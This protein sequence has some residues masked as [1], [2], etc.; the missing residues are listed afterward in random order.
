[1]WVI[2]GGFHILPVRSDCIIEVMEV[3][4]PGLKATAIIKDASNN[5]D[6]I[7]GHADSP[8]LLVP[9]GF[10]IPQVAC[11]C[12]GYTTLMMAVVSL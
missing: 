6:G 3:F 10:I 7:A 9:D 12:T 4:G 11:R 8:L 2:I 1:L 5:V